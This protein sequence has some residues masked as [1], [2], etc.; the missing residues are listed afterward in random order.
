MDVRMKI[1]TKK[2]WRA[3]A[4]QYFFWI[5]LLSSAGFRV[6]MKS[7][8]QITEGK[9]WPEGHRGIF[10][11]S[12]LLHLYYYLMNIVNIKIWSL[13]IFSKTTQSLLKVKGVVFDCRQKMQQNKINLTFCVLWIYLS[14]TCFPRTKQC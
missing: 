10:V 12:A 11:D 9:L 6:K 13:N 2:T 14:A 5:C 8:T 7:S 4:A 1:P 3:E